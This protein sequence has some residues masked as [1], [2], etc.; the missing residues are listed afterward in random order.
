MRRK[1]LNEELCPTFLV[2]GDTIVDIGYTTWVENGPGRW[3]L[4]TEQS[5]IEVTG[6]SNRVIFET[7]VGCFQA[8]PTM[9]LLSGDT[10]T[11]SGGEGDSGTLEPC[12][13]PRRQFADQ[14]EDVDEPV[15]MQT[16]DEE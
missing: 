8:S 12:R 5:A 4:S 3:G 10:I 15:T 14:A 7:P 6:T 13:M 16:M 1:K 11:F 9:V 2:N